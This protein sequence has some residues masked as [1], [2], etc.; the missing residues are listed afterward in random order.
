[1]DGNMLTTEQYIQKIEEIRRQIERSSKRCM[2]PN[3]TADA[4]NSHVFQR[5]GVL[6]QIATDGHVYSFNL[7]SLFKVLKGENPIKYETTGTRD[8]FRFKGFCA[9]H[10]NDL[11][12][13]I[14]NGEVDWYDERNQYLLA[15]KT[16][17]RE[18]RAK[19]DA[20]QLLSNTLKT[21][22][23]GADSYDIP[24]GMTYE[25]LNAQRTIPTL[26]QYKK[27]FE[28]GIYN[29]D[30]SKYYFKVIELPFKLEICL[31]SP[32]TIAEENRY[33]FMPTKDI[34]D[35]V[36]IV[37][38]FPYKDRTMVLL[39]FL[40]GKSNEWCFETRGALWSDD[41]DDTCHALQDILF[42]SDFNCISQQL[43]EAISDKLPLFYDEWR[44]NASNFSGD[45][46]FTANIFE[47]YIKKQYGY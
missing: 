20:Y 32:I 8:A 1:M 40:D 35:T 31:S 17:C 27:L 13:P 14:E 18:L 16:I 26:I 23:W 42:R 21:F 15:Y 9:T 46:T 43:Y 4:I 5:R 7:D 34:K 3:C 47:D 38:I 6:S 29:G 25:I 22:E 11:F 44:N 36:N 39:G 33:A 19:E 28:Q 45:I 37:Q 10:D 24:I 41:I 12:Y 30:Y 2:C